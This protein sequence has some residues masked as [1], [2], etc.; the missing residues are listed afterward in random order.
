VVYML[1][2]WMR[3]MEEALRTLRV[4]EEHK[5]AFV[6]SPNRLIRALLPAHS[7]GIC[8]CVSRSCSVRF[9]PSA[10]GTRYAVR[11]KLDDG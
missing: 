7:F 3:N 9:T 2:R 1:D 11:L 4:L 10:Y 6:S 5:V 8:C